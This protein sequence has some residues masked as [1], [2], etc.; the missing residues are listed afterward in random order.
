MI[1]LLL[2]LAILAYGGSQCSDAE[3]KLTNAV[4]FKLNSRVEGENRL[5]D[6]E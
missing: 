1:Y 2:V 6:L 5:K 4:F 3:Y